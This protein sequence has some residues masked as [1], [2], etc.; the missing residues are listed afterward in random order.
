M[1][2]NS[3]NEVIVSITA[4]IA[5]IASCIG[6]IVQGAK[7]RAEVRSLTGKVRYE[8]G[9]NHGST[10]RDAVN[11]IEESQKQTEKTVRGMSRDIGR[12]ADADQNIQESADHTHESL[13]KR[14]QRI[15]DSIFTTKFKDNK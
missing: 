8:M 12:L 14:I 11:R 4:L 1:D 5:A 2:I 3:V 15:E 9:P 10:L 13:G 6:A 7:I